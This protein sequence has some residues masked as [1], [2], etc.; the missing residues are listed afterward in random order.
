MSHT[1]CHACGGKRLRPEILAVT[2]GGKNIAEFS[3]MSI[4]QALQFIDG[5]K[6]SRRDETIARPI[7]KEIRSRRKFGH[8]SASWQMWDWIT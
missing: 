8:V 7:L 4:H 6:L 1:P 5:L 2:V 3:D